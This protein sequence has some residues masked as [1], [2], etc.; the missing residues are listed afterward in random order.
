MRTKLVSVFLLLQVLL[1]PSVS[2]AQTTE[3]LQAQILQLIAQIRELQAQLSDQGAAD[4]SPFCH[5]FYA[6]IRFGDRGTEVEALQT[7]LAREGFPIVESE[8]EISY[9]GDETVSAVVGFQ[10]KYKNEI[11]TPAGLVSGTGYVGPS[12][13]AKLSSLYSC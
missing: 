11:L 2:F 3:E 1:F 9:F 12:T 10:E 4:L 5:T 7:A 13:R 6:D 8:L